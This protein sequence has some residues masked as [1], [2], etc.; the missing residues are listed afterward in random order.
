MKGFTDTQLRILEK[1]KLSCRD[2]RK[3]FDDYVD[4]ELAPTLRGR[5]DTHINQCPRCQ[6][7]KATYTL[8]MDLAAELH[9]QPVPLEVK[10]RLR[11]ALNQRL[12]ISLPMAT[13]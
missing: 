10:N 6:E 1:F 5:L 13:E 9:E 7:F 8:T 3:I 12:G 2:I 4:D 11:L